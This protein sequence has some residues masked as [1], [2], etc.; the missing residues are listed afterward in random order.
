MRKKGTIVNSQGRFAFVDIDDEPG[1]ESVFIHI[2]NC[3][4]QI[5]ELSIG[6]RLEFDIVA[7]SKKP[8][9]FAGENIVLLSADST[10]NEGKK[11]TDIP[12]EE[13]NR[14][15]GRRK[16][17]RIKPRNNGQSI[18]EGNMEHIEH[19]NVCEQFPDLDQRYVLNQLS[20]KKNKKGKNLSVA[21]QKS[22]ITQS[23]GLR[24]SDSEFLRNWQ[25][26]SYIKLSEYSEVHDIIPDHPESKFVGEIVSFN[27]FK[28]W[29]G[30]IYCKSINSL[31]FVQH[32]ISRSFG[33]I[34]EGA[35]IEFFIGTGL[36]N[37]RELQFVARD[38][39]SNVNRGNAPE[40]AL[41]L[42]FEEFKQ[43]RP[44]VESLLSESDQ[45]L[46]ITSYKNEKQG[47]KAN[48]IVEFVSKKYPKYPYQVLEWPKFKFD[49][50]NSKATS[51]VGRFSHP[52]I[53]NY[54]SA[55]VVL[56]PRDE[57]GEEE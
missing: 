22:R 26:N 20:P 4:D 57:G 38:W 50:Q 28:G 46:L 23:Y 8:G 49:K 3:S 34:K 53:A 31:V 56:F 37:R 1:S 13:K 9:T 24:L 42:E 43:S 32:S 40:P 30:F 25:E 12:R 7:S 51:G 29:Q 2:S 5:K 19:T 55:A 41:S 35:K 6:T 14:Q 10:E 36:D 47:F 18:R 52:L 27:F 44:F 33:S 21:K 39:E 48:E 15:K 45:F 17:K 54:V 11:D 16:K